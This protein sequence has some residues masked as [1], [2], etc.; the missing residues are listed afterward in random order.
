MKSPPPSGSHV[1][2]S[3]DSLNAFQKTLWAQGSKFLP[4]SITKSNNQATFERSSGGVLS[5]LTSKSDDESS[6]TANTPKI[7]ILGSDTSNE[8]LKPNIQ[9]NNNNNNEKTKTRHENPL[10]KVIIDTSPGKQLKAQQDVPSCSIDGALKNVMCLHVKQL[11]ASCHEWFL[12]IYKAKQKIKSPHSTNST[13]NGS[14]QRRAKTYS[15]PTP[16]DIVKFVN[17]LVLHQIRIIAKTINSPDLLP[18]PLQFAQLFPQRSSQLGTLRLDEI[19]NYKDLYLVWKSIQKRRDDFTPKKTVTDSKSNG[20]KLKSKLSTAKCLGRTF[21][22]LVWDNFVLKHPT[23]KEALVKETQI[24]ARQEQTKAKSD[25]IDVVRARHVSLSSILESIRASLPLY[26][27]TATAEKKNV[28]SSGSK[29]S[30]ENPFPLLECP[31]KYLVEC[32]IDIEKTRF[33]QVHPLESRECIWTVSYQQTTAKHIMAMTA[34]RDG[35][36]I[37]R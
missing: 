3:N 32:S 23:L 4:L 35:R 10:P 30:H 28:V 15:E 9:T 14:Q 17:P 18:D 31:Q 5:A 1:T 26:H 25:G 19:K 6:L 12:P 2:S 13:G 37:C 24:I 29:S 33:L 20:T 21:L 11:S 8:S 7:E 36:L 27:E 22:A 16:M 34:K